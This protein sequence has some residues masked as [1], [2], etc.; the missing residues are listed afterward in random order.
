MNYEIEFKIKENGL[1]YCSNCDHIKKIDKF[2]IF[3]KSPDGHFCFCK[4]CK[5]E[6]NKRA[7]INRKNKKTIESENLRI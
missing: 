3:N 6:I 4:E 1:K 7:Y 2:G 5:R